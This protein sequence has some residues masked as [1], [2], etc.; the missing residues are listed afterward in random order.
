MLKIASVL[1]IAAVS[2]TALAPT[3]EAGGWGCQKD[4]YVPTH[5]APMPAAQSNSATNVLNQGQL[6]GGYY[7]GSQV[8]GINNTQVNQALGKANQ[9]N[10]ATNVV[11]Q[12]QSGGGSQSGGISNTQV[13]TAGN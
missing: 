9:S 3:A 5:H 13:N 11:N 10:S 7:P 4:C 1:A 12:H 8:G 6:G 2:A